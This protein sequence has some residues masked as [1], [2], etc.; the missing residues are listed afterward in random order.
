MQMIREIRRIAVLFALFFGLCG[1]AY[2]IAMTFVGQTL[3][4]AKADGS[5]ITRDGR[6]V[7]SSLIAQQFSSAHYFHSRPS[8]V[9]HNAL[10]SGGSNQ[11]MMSREWLEQVKARALQRQQIE[12]FTDPVPADLVMA[13]GSGHDP[14]ISPEAAYYQSERIAKA[15]KIPLEEIN[16]LIESHTEKPELGFLGQPRVHVLHLNLALDELSAKP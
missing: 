8:A 1:L 4:S 15:R 5:L 11:S 6:R 3:V 14:D 2:P 16:R 9:D 13:S 7:G 10:T 12:G